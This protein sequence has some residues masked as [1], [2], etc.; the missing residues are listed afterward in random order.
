MNIETFYD[1][2]AKFCN[3]QIVYTTFFDVWQGDSELKNYNVSG[4]PYEL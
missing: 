4:T 2:Y 3:L 1:P